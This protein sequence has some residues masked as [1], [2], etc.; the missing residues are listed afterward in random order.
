MARTRGCQ[1][2][3]HA[4]AACA[5]CPLRRCVSA[6][7]LPAG[8]E[9]AAHRSHGQPVSRCGAPA[10]APR[11][12]P[13][14]AAP[15]YSMIDHAR[16]RCY[17]CSPRR[18]RPRG[19]AGAEASPDSASQGSPPGAASP[20][21]RQTGACTL[22]RASGEAAH[23]PST[24]RDTDAPG[25]G[26]GLRHAATPPPCEWQLARPAGAPAS[27]RRPL[28]AG[29]PARPGSPLPQCDELA[30]GEQCVGT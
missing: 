9:A 19:P 16:T 13:G 3:L 2:G 8:S 27:A 18:G 11:G 22:P 23:S 12:R 14:I 29:R 28:H 25:P 4:R 21:L 10:Q 7:R 24:S 17:V 6:P 26:A 5:C 20:C 15:R 1:H 30:C